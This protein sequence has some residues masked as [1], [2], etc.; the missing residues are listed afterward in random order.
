MSSGDLIFIMILIGLGLVGIYLIS[1]PI[2]DTYQI[3]YYNNSSS[4]MDWTYPSGVSCIDFMLLAGDPHPLVL[5]AA[6]KEEI[7]RGRNITPTISNKKDFV[8]NLSSNITHANAGG[9]GITTPKGSNDATN[10]SEEKISFK[11]PCRNSSI[12][13][14][15]PS[16]GGG[17]KLPAPGMV[18]SYANCV[19]T[20]V[21]YE[22]VVSADGIT[23]YWR[24][25]EI[26]EINH[27]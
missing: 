10:V 11:L 13:Y 6:C 16:F 12:I 25:S 15:V 7:N 3:T 23:T 22:E 19:D 20:G 8:N 17:Y 18:V 4:I 21:V 9:W 14:T 26:M 2:E 27:E 1:P 5:T 24:K